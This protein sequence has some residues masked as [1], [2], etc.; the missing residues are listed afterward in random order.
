MISDVLTFSLS[1]LCLHTPPDIIF[2]SRHFPDNNTLSF[3]PGL[4]TSSITAT[5]SDSNVSSQRKREDTDQGPAVV[6]KHLAQTN[7]T[8]LWAAKVQS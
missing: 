8:T 3:Y 7:G 6:A 2:V 4:P 5:S 1:Y